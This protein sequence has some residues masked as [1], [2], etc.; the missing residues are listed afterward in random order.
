MKGDGTM[1][2]FPLLWIE[3]RNY[4]SFRKIESLGFDPDY[5]G[6][7][8]D[9]KRVVIE[10]HHEGYSILPVEF[11]GQEFEGHC[12]Q[13]GVIPDRAALQRYTRLRATEFA[14]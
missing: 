6:W 10:L 13:S 3:R 11:D 4:T 8:E 14:A 7:W 12:K 2:Q 5:E 9:Y 1:A